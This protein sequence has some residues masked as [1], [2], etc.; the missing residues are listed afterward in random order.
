MRGI[1]ANTLEIDQLRIWKYFLQSRIKLSQ[2]YNFLEG[3][4]HMHILDIPRPSRKLSN[5]FSLTGDVRY[6]T[7]GDLYPRSQAPVQ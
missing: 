3:L 1:T 7:S 2:R 5:L 6:E 4:T